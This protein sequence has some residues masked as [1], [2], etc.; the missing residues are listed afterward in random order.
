MSQDQLDRFMA[1]YGLESVDQ[2][3]AMMERVGD[4]IPAPPIYDP[5]EMK[6]APQEGAGARLNSEYENT[7]GEIEARDAASRRGMTA[8]ERKNT[9]PDLGDENTVFAEDTQGTP[10]MK[11]ENWVTEEDMDEYLRAGT[12]ENK[13][14]REALAK[15]KKILLTNEA[16]IRE[17]IRTS[18]KNAGEN[19]TAAY[20]K[21]DAQLAD[22]ISEITVG[23]VDIK[24]D[25]LEF[26]PFD[27]QHAFDE[28]HNPKE[29]G[30]ISLSVADYESIPTYFSTFD[31][32]LD[33]H[34]YGS[35]NQ[36]TITVSKKVGNG[37][38]VIVEVVS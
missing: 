13:K 14:K 24:G 38:V 33:V 31:E 21:V 10:Y 16:E 23:D 34:T 3:D 28:H 37:R 30:D 35:S 4:G 1:A 22:V 12:R 19:A 27:I 5:V 25:F 17:Y 36:T 15:G 18:I 9:P 11:A 7:A 6:N 26:V 2:L 29:T 8:E 20:G 32:L